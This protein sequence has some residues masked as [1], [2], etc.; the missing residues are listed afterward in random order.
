MV[1]N[2]TMKYDETASPEAIAFNYSIFQSMETSSSEFAPLQE[3][4]YSHF[5]DINIVG[6]PKAGTSHMYQI[7]TTHPQMT[8][9]REREKELCLKV[10]EDPRNNDA[11]LLQRFFEFNNASRIFARS[12]EREDT[13]GIPSS[14]E[15]DRQMTVN[16]CLHHKPTLMMRQYLE[17][18]DD[19]KIILL[20]RD[21]ADWVWAAY[22]FW[23]RPKH[24]DALPSGGR[25]E[26]WA[27]SPTQYRSPEHFH[28]MLLG[29]D[30]LFSFVEFVSRLRD[31]RAY[32]SARI[33]AAAK[34][35]H[36][37]NVLMLKSEDMAPDQVES[38]GVIETLA[39]FLGVAKEDF[40]ETV[41][42]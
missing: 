13:G 31:Y 28:E 8:R 7:L 17:R 33:V 27:Y 3:W 22:N 20:L 35:H 12:R 11:T 32:E 39:D 14:T 6:I 19:S 37:H 38:S 23:R 15:T 24:I 26:G 1:N 2:R 41:V 42:G 29:G 30:R 40:N 10:P 16:A 9:F 25:R 34:R 18:V 21:P 36:P 4:K 5:P